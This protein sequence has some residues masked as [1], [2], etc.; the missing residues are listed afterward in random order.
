MGWEKRRGKGRYYTRTQRVNGRFVRKYIGTG[1]TGELAATTDA[2]SRVERKIEAE[3][4]MATQR[5]YEELTVPL[6]ELCLLT[7]FLLK[8]SLINAGYHQHNRGEWRR[9]KH[10]S[11]QND[12]P[13]DI[14]T[15]AAG[16]AGEG[17]Q[18]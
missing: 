7:D 1:P 14:S 17:Q 8:A 12:R 13:E 4:E 9:R 6:D 3:S 5:C 10:V 18:G 15:R 16:A 2:L 11:A